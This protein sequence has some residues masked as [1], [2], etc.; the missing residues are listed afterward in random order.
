MMGRKPSRNL[1]LPAGMRARHRRSKVWYYFDAGGKPRKEIPLGCDYALA[2]REW[3]KLKITE[4]PP[5]AITFRYATER[6]ARE[7]IPTKAPRTQKDNFVQLHF[8]YQFFDN[9]PAPLDQIE[10]QHI[11]QY[12]D[13]RSKPFTIGDK[14]Y[15]GSK[16]QANREK[17]LFSHI[18]NKTRAWGY[19]GK[20]NP[21]SGIEGFSERPRSIYVA[22]TDFSA[23]Y[24]AASEPVK[25]FMDLLYLT[26]QRPSDVLRMRRSDIKDGVL[27]IQQGKTDTPLRMV[28][29]G[30]LE[31][32]I[33]R[34]MSRKV[35]SLRLVAS[36]TGQP[37]TLGG[38]RARFKKDNPSFQLR[39][40]RAKAETDKAED[41]GDIRQAQK[42]LGHS[43]VTM[44][45]TYIRSRGEKVKPTK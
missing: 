1:N 35:T 9:P 24:K 28:V 4:K 8:L 39:D 42:Q 18:W 10:P 32:V 31:A 33:D 19:T 43:T 25:D 30:Q 41:T 20:P 26:G 40:L 36:E 21:C 38:L 23:A 44:T 22:D 45:E 15:E 5:I 34:I 2:V 13:W 17:A 12:L 29:E 27:Y 16:T 14:K 6:Y 37:L 3:A 7:V 11:S